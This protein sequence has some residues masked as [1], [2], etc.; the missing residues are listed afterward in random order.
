MRAGKPPVIRAESLS[1]RL[2]YSR[3]IGQTSSF[4][5]FDLLPESNGLYC[6]EAAL[7]KLAT[8]F[9]SFARSPSCKKNPVTRFV[10]LVPNVL[11]GVLE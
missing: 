4:N 6:L 9:F 7:M 2:L 3:R 8:F 5:G 11:A 10:I 1:A